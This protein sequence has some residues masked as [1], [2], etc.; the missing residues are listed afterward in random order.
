MPT[1]L[2]ELM[3]LALEQHIIHLD[4]FTDMDELVWSLLETLLV[5]EHLL[6]ELLTWAK[7]RIH[8][9]DI[10]VGL[11]AR[12]ADEVSCHVIDLDRLAHVKNEDLSAFC[13]ICRLEDQTHSFGDGH[14]VADDAFIGYRDGASGSYLTLKEGDDAAV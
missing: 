10:H 6:V 9:L 5:H 11:V 1:Q 2:I 7:A 8:N 14:K 13:V 3:E 4:R 12:E